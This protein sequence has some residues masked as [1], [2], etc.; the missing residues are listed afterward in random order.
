MVD[1]QNAGDP[2]YRK[3][4]PNFAS[5]VGYQ[6]ALELVFEGATQPSGYTEPVLHRRRKEAK[7]TYA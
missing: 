6:A 2:T 5:S 7:V 1:E 3:M 4:A